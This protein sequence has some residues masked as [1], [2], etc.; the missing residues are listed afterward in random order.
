MKIH[1]FQGK[2]LFRKAGVPVLEG[3]VAKTPE[4]AAQAYDKLGGKI[5]VVKSQIHAGGRGKGTVIDNPKQHGVVL[6]KSADEARAAAE[7][8]LGKKLVTIQT[9]PEGQTVNQVFVEAGCDI[10]RELYLGIVLDRGDKKPVLMVST[11]G[12]MEIETVAE[13][14]PELIF[15]EHFDPHVGLEPYQVRKL[16]KKLGITGA[17]AKAASRFMPAMCRFYVDY[18][19]EMAEINPLVITGDDQMV[20]LDAKIT[21]DNNALYRHPE[22]AE[23]RDLSEEEPSEVRATDAGLSYVK[24]EGNIGC[25]VNGAGLAM[26][27]M[28]II[29]YHGGQPANFLD[30]GGSANEEQV[31]E[32]FRILLSDPN[33]K[34]VLVNIFGG[35][36]RC[37]T[38]A[39]AVIAASK[40]VGFKVP[41]VVRLEGTEVEEGRKMLA[42]SD[43]D[44]ITASDITDAAQKIVAATGV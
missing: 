44:I 12:G 18:D 11:E 9:G 6:C 38:I 10:A 8:L 19:C 41:L 13:E 42:E 36:A 14:T 15:K 40:T 24:L 34:G 33:V 39:A 2:E 32:A 16:C 25:L 20:A 31:T 22:L 7:G 4:E 17:A 27:T 37:T 29:K 26:S 3:I 1:E 28:D 21:F 35:I 23:F 30:V 43:V 5:A